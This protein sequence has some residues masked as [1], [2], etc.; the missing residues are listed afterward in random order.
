MP[1]LV[2]P[3][4][5]PGWR[6]SRG[7]SRTCHGTRANCG[8]PAWRQMPACSRPRRWPGSQ[9][10]RSPNPDGL[11]PASCI[12]SL[13][14]QAGGTST[15]RPAPR[16]A[17]STPSSPNRIGPS[18]TAATRSCRTGAWS[19]RGPARVAPAS[20]WSRTAGRWRRRCRSPVMRRCKRRAM[21]SW[22]SPPPRPPR[23]Q[24]SD[25]T[26]SGCRSRCSDAARNRNST[27]ASF[28][29]PRPSSFRPRAERPPTPCSTRPDILTR[30][31][32]RR[33]GHH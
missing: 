1:L 8:R 6:G 22:P 3:L 5:G 15:T 23:R 20:G 33:N 14:A 16:S 32:R 25:S 13:T 9:A 28:R 18:A 26:R 12:S 27:R 30:P 2:S 17:R 31:G 10:S 29:C 19:P 21:A 4:T 24:S 7:T 11:P